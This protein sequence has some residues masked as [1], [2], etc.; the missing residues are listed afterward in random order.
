MEVIRMSEISPITTVGQL[1]TERPNRSHVF[2]RWGIDYCCG[3]NK[4]LAQ[5]CEEKG[6][7]LQAVLNELKRSDSQ[8]SDEP[9]DWAS[10]SLGE[11]ADHIEATHHAYLR[12]ELPRL[13]GL[14]EK[15]VQA[16]GQQHPEL[17]QVQ[18]IFQTLRA[19]LESH[20]W[21]EENILFPMCRE[22][23]TAEV[24]PRFHCGSI[25]NPIFVMEMEH[26][27][28]GEALRQLRTLT[29]G[30]IPPEDACNTYRAMLDALAHLEVDLHVHIHKE[31]NILF[32]R[33]M[34]KEASLAPVA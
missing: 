16:H 8:A 33:A 28:A 22:L 3:G 25:Q 13:T 14:I 23:D 20:T 4:P 27:R 29:G 2:E 12:Q 31:N 21:K 19:E 30:F 7:S 10:A 26:D 17:H 15:V 18:N 11:L 1:V 24:P 9:M 5:A 32:P 6:I 34:E